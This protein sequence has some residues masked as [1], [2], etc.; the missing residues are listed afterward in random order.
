MKS[1]KKIE[2]HYLIEKMGYNTSIKIIADLSEGRCLPSLH[3]V[4]AR[5]EFPCY[6]VLL[7][8]HLVACLNLPVKHLQNNNS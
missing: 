2:L 8:K 6:Q 7:C 4:I 5:A 3:H 1:L